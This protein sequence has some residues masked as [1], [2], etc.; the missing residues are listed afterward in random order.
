MW[1]GLEVPADFKKHFDWADKHLHKKIRKI[2]QK[3]YK[4]IWR[5][6]NKVEEKIDILLEWY[7]QWWLV[8]EEEHY[9]K[10]N[11]YNRY[12]VSWW[13]SSEQIQLQKN[14]RK[15]ELLN[16]FKQYLKKARAENWKTL[17][18]SF[19]TKGKTIDYY[20]DFSRILEA[21]QNKLDTSPY[22]PEK[23]TTTINCSHLDYVFI[24]YLTE[25]ELFSSLKNGWSARYEGIREY[26]FNNDSVQVLLKQLEDF[27]NDKRKITENNLYFLNGINSYFQH[28]EELIIFKRK[29]SN[30]FTEEEQSSNL[31]KYYELHKKL[32]ESKIWPELTKLEKEYD[33]WCEKKYQEYITEINACE[34]KEKL[35]ANNSW[36]ISNSDL[37]SQISELWDLIYSENYFFDYTSEREQQLYNAWQARLN[38]IRDKE[39]Q[40]LELENKEKVKKQEKSL[41]KEKK[42]SKPLT[43]T[44]KKK[45]AKSFI[46]ALWQI[47]KDIQDDSKKEV[48]LVNN[49]LKESSFISWINDLIQPYDYGKMIVVFNKDRKEFRLI[50]GDKRRVGRVSLDVFDTTEL[51]SRIHHGS[52]ED[53]GCWYH[54]EIDRDNNDIVVWWGAYMYLGENKIFIWNR[55]WDFWAMSEEIVQKCI[56]TWGYEL[57]THDNSYFEPTYNVLRR[58]EIIKDNDWE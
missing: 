30:F 24:E 22:I 2:E 29:E 19:V 39:R 48:R 28:Y 53:Y 15:L 54:S 38:V 5:T 45:R 9:E 49:I 1:A 14:E 32:N 20:G 40:K 4:K 55:S 23:D 41:E 58:S 6:K 36:Y 35:E 44:E 42:D 50:L 8:S 47:N 26:Y 13:Y 17:W 18:N 12:L 52:L 11:A 33:E 31:E 21:F 3:G 10:D 16:K 51:L 37:E 7:L 57:L 43:K 27:T 25:N 46:T 56:D 34:D